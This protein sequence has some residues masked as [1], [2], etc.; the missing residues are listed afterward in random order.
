MRPASSLASGGT[1]PEAREPSGSLIFCSSFTG[2]QGL[3]EGFPAQAS[4]PDQFPQPQSFSQF[5][6][7]SQ[8]C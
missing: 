2:P 1:D 5:T 3:G 7:D 4:T 6:Q 8:E